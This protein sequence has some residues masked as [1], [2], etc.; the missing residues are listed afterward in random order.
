MLHYQFKLLIF[1]FLTVMTGSVI[2]TPQSVQQVRQLASDYEHALLDY[3]PEQGTF[4]GREPERNDRFRDHSYGALLRWHSV[5]DKFYQRLLQIN[6]SELRDT[7]ELISYQLLKENFEAEKAARV[8]QDELWN[9]NPLF[10]WHTILVYIAEAQPVGTEDFRQ[11]ALAR[12]QT[13]DKM[14][15]D[16]IDNLKLGLKRGYTAPKPAVERVINQLKMILALPAEESP[17]YRF[18]KRDGDTEFQQQMA[19]IISEQINPAIQKYVTY[20]EQDYLRLARSEVGVSALP[21]GEQCYYAKVRQY[22]TL[23]IPPRHIYHYGL[24]QVKRVDGE[25]QTIGQNIFNLNDVKKIFTQAKTSPEYLFKSEQEMLAYNFAALDRVKATVGEWFDMMPKAE[26]TIEPYPPFRASTGAAGEYSPP[27]KDGSRPGIFY[28]NTYQPEKRSR[29]DQ[30][31]TLFHELVPGHHFQV[32][33][34]Q[35]NSALLPINDYL[36]NSGYGEGWAL[37]VERLADEM[38]LYS[39]DVSRLGMLSNEA[40]R[41]ARLVVD[42]GMH[43]FHWTRDEA[44]DYLKQHTA[45][46]EALIQ[47]EVD[48][49][50]MMPGQATSYM[51]GK[52]MIEQLRQQAQEAQGKDFDIRAFHNQVLKNGTVTLPMLRQQIEQW[53]T[54]SSKPNTAKKLP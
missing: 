45:L 24:R 30:E 34:A 6:A 31:A 5:Q 32:A 38:G 27:A 50:I 39:D 52:R 35:E 11:Q 19:T 9:V 43:M 8:C 21:H 14:V 26:A 23:N 42:P 18:A 7:P 48:R 20:L 37:Y 15:E 12:W 2:A 16:E 40:M 46:D 47:G 28:I 54:A 22:T 53:L 41:S 4:V 1:I 3:S 36:W 13:I 25:V 44:V 33:L 49:Y 51:L 17:F 10:G 29:V